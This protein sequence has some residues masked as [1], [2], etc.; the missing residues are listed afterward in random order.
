MAGAANIR[1]IEVPPDTTVVSLSGEIDIADR[2]SIG[3]RITDLAHRCPG[4]VVIDLTDVTYLDSSGVGMLLA[5]NHVLSTRGRRCVV[6]CPASAVPRR[7]LDI[8]RISMVMPVVETEPE[9]LNLLSPP[10]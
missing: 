5:T 3:G 1:V 2:P 9:A 8:A 7:V 4:D 10:G 6:I